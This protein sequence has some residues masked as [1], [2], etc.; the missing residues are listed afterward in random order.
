MTGGLQAAA[1]AAL[2]AYGLADAPFTEV[3]TSYNTV[4]RVD[5]PGGPLALR[6]GPHRSVHHPGAPAAE[7]AFLDELTARGA[8]VPRVL[9]AADGDASVTVEV[10]DLPG[11]RVCMLLEWVPG[12]PGR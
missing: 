6:I 12:R 9:P 7:R 2:A 3:S 8:A 10:A 5:A 1:H 11:A 4:C